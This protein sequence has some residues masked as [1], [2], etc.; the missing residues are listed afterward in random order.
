MAKKN[1]VG[2]DPKILRDRR[3][4]FRYFVVI[5]N[6]EDW[7]MFDDLDL[8]CELMGL[9]KGVVVRFFDERGYYT[10]FEF[11]VFRVQSESGT[12]HR[13]HFI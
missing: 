6:G 11:T 10:G 4:P 12:S 2:Y 3:L 13:G 5:R 8:M 9:D 7:R 1:S